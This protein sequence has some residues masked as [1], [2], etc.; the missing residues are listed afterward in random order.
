MNLFIRDLSRIC[1]ERLLDEKWLISPSLRVGYQWLDSVARSGQATVNVR[2]KTLKRFALDLAS[3]EMSRKGVGFISSR[4]AIVLID[5]IWSKLRV[6]GKGYLPEPQLGLRLPETIFN[7]IDDIRLAGLDARQM[8]SSEFEAPEKGE[9]LAAILEE[10][11]EALKARRSVDYADVLRMAIS[12]VSGSD[13]ALGEGVVVLM[14]EDI[15]CASMEKAL[16]DVLPSE[17]LKY[18]AVDCPCDFSDSGEVETDALLL[19][20]VPR[21]SEAPQPRQDGTAGIFRA[22]GEANEIREVLRRC[23]ANGY[24]LDK[25]EI[26]HTDADTY[27]PLIYEIAGR[28]RSGDER[29]EKDP[30]VTFAEGIPTRYSRPG[31]ALAAW[32]N[33]IREDYPQAILVRMIQDGLIGVPGDDERLDFFESANLLRA[34]GIGWGRER[35]LDKLDKQIVKLEKKIVQKGH[36]RNEDIEH[37]SEK[38]SN[39]QKRLDGTVLL[40]ELVEKLLEITPGEKADRRELLEKSIRFVEKFARNVNEMDNYSSH[41]FLRDIKNLISCLEHEKDDNLSL[42]VW[43]WLSLLP[44][45]VR[46]IGEGP[47]PGCIHVSNIYSG[48]HS[49]RP[50]TF[51]V[52]LDDS[53]FP[54]AGLQDPLLLDRERKKLSPGLDTAGRRLEKKVGDFAKL[55]ARLRGN[56]T[57]SYCCR[58]L[59]DDRDMYPAPVVLAAYRI[60]SENRDREGQLGDLTNWLPPP[61]SFAPD[62]IEKCL[63]E[64]EWWLWRMCGPEEIEQPE[65]LLR[66]HFPHL[67]QGQIAAHHRAGDEFGMYDGKVTDVGSD[68]DPTSPDGPIMSSSRLKTLGECPLRYFFRYVLR[69]DLPEDLTIDNTIWLDHLNYGNL[70]HEVFHRFMSE[71]KKQDKLP[72]FSRDEKR[73]C[74]I[75]DQC[76]GEYAEIYPSPNENAFRTQYN[77]M[78]GDVSVFLREQEEICKTSKPLFFEASIGM[79]SEG[80]ITGIDTTEPE[81]INLPIGKNIRVQG[82]IDRVDQVGDEAARK[83]SVWDYKTGST[84]KYEQRD[85]PFH[86]GRVIQHALYVMIA[87]ARLREKISSEAEVTDFGYFFPGSKNPGLIKSYDVRELLSEVG[88]VLNLL[89]NLARSGTFVATENEED[90]KY[91][92][93]RCICGDGKEAAAIVKKKMQ[94]EDNKELEDFKELRD[95]GRTRK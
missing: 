80:E 12:V 49:G 91:C 79:E 5:R 82:R 81:L 68:V 22:V 87:A 51:I 41:A 36:S 76:V 2:I 8:D 30:P 18:L 32:L 34:V 54:G 74:E 94:N 71:L 4:A 72:V 65:E 23:V 83:F 9:E 19:R 90:C 14:P 44:K 56:I 67:R 42:D 63:D 15:E 69:I 29:K 61:A 62:K 6:S 28:F 31:R 59:S 88:D 39:A 84:H 37:A 52:G 33:W 11:V 17:R 40:R 60:L 75:L 47:R 85:Y 16:L 50:Y 46:V 55:L 27:V 73:L 13:G 53:R 66:E 48:G 1:R 24:S 64:A 95:R 45:N 89:C 77:K 38:V 57:L 92:D 10:Y 7:T 35:Y 26:I 25:V 21:P 20:W 58:N 93:Y 3:S 43:E 86:Q 70:L 78:K